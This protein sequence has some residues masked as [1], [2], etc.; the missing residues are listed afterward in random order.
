MGIRFIPMDIVIEDIIDYNIIFS[1]FGLKKT[2]SLHSTTHMKK[3]N[4][5]NNNLTFITELRVS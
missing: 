2:V 3:E 4:Q 1:T 5:K